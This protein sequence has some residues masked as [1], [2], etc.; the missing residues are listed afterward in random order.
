ML[1]GIPVLF[2]M[3]M[4]AL[5]Q[6]FPVPEMFVD[7]TGSA[8]SRFDVKQ[9]VVRVD[10]KELKFTREVDRWVDENGIQAENASVDS[11]LGWV[12]ETK[13]LSVAIAQYP[14]DNE[15]AS[16]TLIGYDMS[17][18]DTVRIARN[19]SNQWIL[20]NG[21]NVLRLHPLE[22]GEVLTHFQN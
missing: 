10:G 11:L 20:E 22:S 1:A 18:L 3:T 15:V 14:Q 5:T 9:V 4:N 21:D 2:R 6:L 8:V 17:P 7:S 12:L 19:D 13:P 16:V